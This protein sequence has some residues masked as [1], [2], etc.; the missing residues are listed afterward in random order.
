MGWDD[1]NRNQDPWGNRND[2]GPPDL[3]QMLSNF[4][5]KVGISFSGKG[6]SSSS[7][8]GLFVG[9]FVVVL[10][11]IV[12]WVA[13]GFTIVGPSQRAVV[14]RFGEYYR[15]V[16]ESNGLTWFPPLIDSVYKQDVVGLRTY[17]Y[18]SEMFTSDENLVNV[19]FRIQY[20]ISN[21]KD[22]LFSVESARKTLEQ[23]TQSAVRQVVG[24]NKFDDIITTGREKVAVGVREELDRL[25]SSYH[26]GIDIVKVNLGKAAPPQQVDAAFKDVNKASQ[27]K[28]TAINQATKVQNEIIP[29]A[30]G[31]AQKMELDAQAKS[32]QLVNDAEANV[33]VYNA[34]RKVYEANPEV[35]RTRLYLDAMGKIY[36][37]SSKVLLDVKNSGNL[38]YLPLNKL[39]ENT[40]TDKPQG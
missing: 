37:N 38:M 10:V 32:I 20:K 28:D 36:S 24:D 25:L 14:L 15:T 27:D 40:Q 3:D 1:N 34:L 33:A 4:F 11:A 18:S 13:S 16:P 31:Q 6:G 17:Q 7:G 22:Y 8:K 23:A 21:L 26:A 12:I 2:K 39:V 35:T 30:K 9:L 19:N 5:K 29:V